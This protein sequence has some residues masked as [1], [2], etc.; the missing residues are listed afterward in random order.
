[1][2]SVGKRWCE[3]LEVEADGRGVQLTY[4]YWGDAWNEWVRLD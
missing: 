2:D 1:M 4:T 3:V